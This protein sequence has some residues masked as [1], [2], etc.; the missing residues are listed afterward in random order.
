M[1]I[2]EEGNSEDGFSVLP[3]VKIT[4]ASVGSPPLSFKLKEPNHEIANEKA[5]INDTVTKVLQSYNWSLVHS[6]SK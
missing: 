5:E 3:V 1:N 6:P 4:A 2:K